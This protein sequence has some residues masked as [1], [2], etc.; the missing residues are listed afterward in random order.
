MIVKVEFEIDL[1][2]IKHKEEEL[3]EWL[4]FELGD[5]NERESDNPFNNIS[6]DPITG[7]FEW[8]YV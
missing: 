5:N 4:R 2:R 6:A 7:T 8:K 1:G 3:E